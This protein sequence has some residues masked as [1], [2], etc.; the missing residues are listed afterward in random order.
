MKT[1]TVVISA[2]VTKEITGVQAKN[3]DEAIESAHD[4][5]S[6]LNDE[7]KEKYESETV[8]HWEE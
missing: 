6:V 8:D 4:I 7:Y 1:Y 3:E 5:F 2:T